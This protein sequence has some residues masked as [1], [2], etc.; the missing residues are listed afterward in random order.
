MEIKVRHFKVPLIGPKKV[1]KR[2]SS[3]NE[4]IV[5]VSSVVV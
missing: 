3:Y 4:P 1:F 5:Y 2:P